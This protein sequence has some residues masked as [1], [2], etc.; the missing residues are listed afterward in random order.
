MPRVK[1][2]FFGDPGEDICE[3]EEIKYLF[4]FPY[5]I[6]VVEGQVVNSYDQLVQIASQ[7][8][9]KD[10]EFIEIVQVPNIEGG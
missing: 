2:K 6:I 1:L 3:L 5:G 4:D 7:G 8:K 9:Y 10:Q